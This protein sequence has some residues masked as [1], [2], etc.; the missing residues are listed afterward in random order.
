MKILLVEDNEYDVK[1]A[2]HELE[3][4]PNKPE[5]KIVDKEKDFQKALKEFIPDVIITDYVLPDFDGMRA[6]KISL[7]HES[8]S[9]SYNIH[10][11]N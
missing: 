10:R 7:E 9:S 8:F 2:L 5:I 4:L 11:F 6:L 1:L 3:S